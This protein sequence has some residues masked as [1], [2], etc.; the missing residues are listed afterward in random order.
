MNR[1]TILLLC[2]AACGIAVTSCK[3]KKNKEKEDIIVEK[4]VMKPQ[5]TNVTMQ[6]KE[7]NGETKWVGG[8][9]Y[10]YHITRAANRELS[11]VESHGVT[12]TDNSIRLTI[13]R[14]D[15]S[16]FVSKVFGKSNFSQYLSAD[17]QKHGVLLG[18]DLESAEGDNLNFVI[19]VGCPDEGYDDYSMVQMTVN[20][21]GDFSFSHYTPKEEY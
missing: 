14:N 19:T 2:A 17:A 6:T 18:M 15:G 21:M 7:T 8:S 16:E 1:K 3:D 12:Y 10:S 9:T 4:V 13:N 20:R 11:E 5:S